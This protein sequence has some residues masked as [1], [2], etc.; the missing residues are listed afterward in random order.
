MPSQNHYHILNLPPSATAE[1][2]KKAFRKLALQ[3][4]PDKNTAG[5]R[6]AA[7]KFV[8]IQE[9]YQTLSDSRKRAAYD[10]YLHTKTP[11]RA[12]RQ[13]ASTPQE[14][15]QLSTQLAKDILGSDPYRINRDLLCCK[16]RDILSSRH[17]Q[18]LA[19]EADMDKNREI[20]GQ[21][22]LAAH[23]LPLPMLA[24]IIEQLEQLTANDPVAMN[25]LKQF[26]R[27]KKHQD[28]WDQYKVY[29]A[30]AITA[31]ACLLIL[32]SENR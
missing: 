26:I 22:M 16:I 3:Y 13:P 18:L 14:I 19:T 15:L 4:H 31:L 11:N 1:E 7:A 32:L 17:L 20:A 23:L 25:R 2:I 29:V 24:A 21:L 6:I 28:Y 5:N 10:Y 30:L 8:E 12:A 27:Q 9:A